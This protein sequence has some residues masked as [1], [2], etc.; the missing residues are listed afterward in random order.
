MFSTGK[1]GL[2]MRGVKTIASTHHHVPQC[3][4]RKKEKRT[5]KEERGKK[6][7]ER[8]TKKEE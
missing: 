1:G 7:E 8:R 2:T 6:N 5:K 4:K 3:L